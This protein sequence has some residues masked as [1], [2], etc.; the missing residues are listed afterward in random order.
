MH[1][2]IFSATL[3]AYGRSRARDQIQTSAVTFA[4]EETTLDP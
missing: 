2:F 3:V 4:T 1:L